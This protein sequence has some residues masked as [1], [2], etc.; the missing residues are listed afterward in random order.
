L[1][2]S[3]GL[4]A[5]RFEIEPEITAKLLR[6]RARVREVPIAYR[7]RREGKKIGP[8]DGIAACYYLAKWYVK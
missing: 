1:F 6:R 2:Q 5:N 4:T 7:A 3:L 8:R